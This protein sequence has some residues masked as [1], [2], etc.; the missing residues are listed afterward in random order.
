MAEQIVILNESYI[1]IDNS[2]HINWMDKGNAM[3]SIPN[4]VHAVIW[5][6][7]SGQNEIQS[8]EPSTQNMTD[9]TDLSA[10]SDAVGATTIAD[11]LVWGETRK[12]QI[13][14]AMV[15]YGEAVIAETAAGVSPKVTENQTWKDYDTNYS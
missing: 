12:E 1:L 2:I 5:N 4:T 14:L 7:L 10:T 15:A 13:N 11:L 6:T 9:N 3:P 8:K